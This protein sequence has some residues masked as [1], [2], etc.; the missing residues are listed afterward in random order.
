[1][2]EL[3]M[4]IALWVR[5]R[6]VGQTR[7][8]YVSTLF[9]FFSTKRLQALRS[10]SKARDIYRCHC[11]PTNKNVLHLNIFS[12]MHY[13]LCGYDLA[14]RIPCVANAAL[15]IDLCY[16]MIPFI[17]LILLTSDLSI[18]RVIGYFW[19]VHHVPKCMSCQNSLW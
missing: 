3:D 12:V 10:I 15:S 13:M 6:P 2:V 17:T 18:L 16:F 5:H 11:Y 19:P 1:M 9:R 7:F 8:A 14:Q 4:M